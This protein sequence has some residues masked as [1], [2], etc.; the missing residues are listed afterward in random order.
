MNPYGPILGAKDMAFKDL[1]LLERLLLLYRAL[2]V[3]AQR[4][5]YTYFQHVLLIYLVV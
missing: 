1:L 2:T 4:R 3:A 5:N